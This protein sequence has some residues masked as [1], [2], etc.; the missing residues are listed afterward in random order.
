M[1]GIKFLS[2]WFPEYAYTLVKRKLLTPS[3]SS[4]RWAK[5]S[6]RKLYRTKYGCI[7]TYTTVENGDRGERQDG[8]ECHYIWLVHGWGECTSVYSPYQTLG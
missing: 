4:V 1:F 2:K 7:R 3:S 6:K 8:S 5:E